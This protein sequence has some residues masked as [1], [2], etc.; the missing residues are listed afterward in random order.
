MVSKKVKRAV[1]EDAIYLE[2]MQCHPQKQNACRG[3][4][5]WSEHAAKKMLDKDLK[6]GIGQKYEAKGA[7]DVKERVSIC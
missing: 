4:P 5:F 6:D 1:T 3:T 7:M 2:D